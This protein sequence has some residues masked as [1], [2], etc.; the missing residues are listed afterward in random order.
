MF[1]APGVVIDGRTATDQDWIDDTIERGI[2]G[3]GW[4]R[5]RLRGL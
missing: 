1:R 2:A 5:P 4:S 3:C